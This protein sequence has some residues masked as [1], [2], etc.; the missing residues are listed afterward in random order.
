MLKIREL[1][2]RA[3]QELGARFD[4]REFHDV[5]L[6]DGAMPLDILEQQVNSYIT[7]KKA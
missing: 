4:Q 5:V 3:Q 1:R 6:K 7:R 2:D